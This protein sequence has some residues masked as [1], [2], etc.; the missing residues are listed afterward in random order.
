MMFPAE[1]VYDKKLKAHVHTWRDTERMLVGFVYRFD[2]DDIRLIY[3]SMTEG[4]GAIR[5]H[6]TRAR[7]IEDPMQVGGWRLETAADPSKDEVLASL[8]LPE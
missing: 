8:V 2:D 1:G 7:N 6:R 5:L 3:M 4:T